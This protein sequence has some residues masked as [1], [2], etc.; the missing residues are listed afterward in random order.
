[1]QEKITA[2][3]I[4]KNETAMLEACLNTVGWCDQVVVIDSGSTDDTA[5]IAEQAGAKVVSFAHSSFS[6]LRNEALKH[7]DTEWLLYL[8]ADE[9]ILP[10]LAKEIQVHI[11]TGSDAALQLER[12]NIFFGQAFSAG[13]WSPD[14]VT[15][16]FRKTAL[17]GWQGV[18][19]ESPE[20]EGSSARLH[21]PLVHLTHRSVATGLQ[22]SAVW[23]GLEAQ[24]LHDSITFAVTP[25]TVIRKGVMEFLR[26]GFFWRGYSDGQPGLME[27][28]T[29]GI[30]KMLVYMQVWE[31]QQKPS[32]PQQYKTAEKEIADLWAKQS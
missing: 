29:Q 9:R 1:M 14:L 30:N 15:R 12:K 2:V 20:F 17:K 22:K 27:A 3:I 31:L 11:E 7:V 32:I 21:I 8:D 23:T 13:G 18:V 4:A 26:R 5:K 28:I 6:R 24:L 25:R 16:I 10:Q 19:H